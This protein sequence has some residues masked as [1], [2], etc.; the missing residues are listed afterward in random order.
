[1]SS[2]SLKNLPRQYCLEQKNAQNHRNYLVNKIKKVPNVSKLPDLGINM[3]NMSG[4]YTHNVLSNNT[5][6]LESFLF[7]IGTSNLVI[8]YEKPTPNINNL[9][10]LKFFNKPGYCIPDPLIMEKRQRPVGPFS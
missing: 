3:G 9:D 10:D 1:M 4:G 5:S 8:P 6:D 2:T 7:G